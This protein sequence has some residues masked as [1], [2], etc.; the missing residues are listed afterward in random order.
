[1]AYLEYRKEDKLVVD[2]HENEPTEIPEGH[3]IAYHNEFEPGHEYEFVIYVNEVDENGVV[4]STEEIRQNPKIV[5]E[6]LKTLQKE[7]LELKNLL[8]DLAEIVLLGGN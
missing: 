5:I 2:I 7:N 6:Q 8:A 1:M 4:T 3:R